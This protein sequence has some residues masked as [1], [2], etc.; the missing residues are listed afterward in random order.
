MKSHKVGI[1]SA[2][3]AS[4]C[5]VGPLLLAA[6][7]LG[8]LGVSAVIG[9]YHWY[10]IAGAGIILGVA[11]FGYLRE[12]R[13]CQTARCEMAGDRAARMTLAIATLAGLGFLGL[14]VYSYAGDSTIAATLPIPDQAHV[15]AEKVAIPVDGMTCFSCTIAVERSLTRLDGI[16]EVAASVADKRLTVTYDPER[17]S[18]ARMVEAVNGTGYRAR[19]PD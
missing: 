4:I 5:C 16:I 1:I 17:I 19:I 7:G 13:R 11:W 6:L 12:R 9:E 14:N 18:V 10:F 2:V 8:S 15:T 3:L